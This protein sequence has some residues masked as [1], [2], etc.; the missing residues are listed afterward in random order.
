MVESGRY[1]RQK[2]HNYKLKFDQIRCKLRPK[3]NHKIDSS[4]S[5][6]SGHAGKTSPL[7]LSAVAL[8]KTSKMGAP[9]SPVKPPDSSKPFANGGLRLPALLP[10][11]L[12]P[13]G[14]K[15]RVLEVSGGEEHER[16]TRILYVRG[17]RGSTSE[18]RLS[19]RTVMEP[20]P[21]THSRTFTS[22]DHPFLSGFNKSRIKR[23]ISRSTST[24]QNSFA[25]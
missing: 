6:G 19:F 12:L 23:N 4:H 5:N 13:I 22:P 24:L 10:A 8:R 3:V 17:L 11:G 25:L 9:A 1:W 21:V 18:D 14:H 15:E 7:S 16:R 2:K 20:L